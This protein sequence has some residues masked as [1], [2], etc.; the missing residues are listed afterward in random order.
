MTPRT[1]S[2]VPTRRSPT[3]SATNSSAAATSEADG[4]MVTTWSVMN[5]VIR[6][7]APVTVA[8]FLG[9]LMIGILA[10]HSAGSSRAPPVAG[11]RICCALDRPGD[12]AGTGGVGSA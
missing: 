9:W 5:R 4:E 8:S 2:I 10:C 3:S 7:S 6:A 11:L 12:Q 1:S